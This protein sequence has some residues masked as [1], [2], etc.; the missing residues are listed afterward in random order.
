MCIT[1]LVIINNH[2]NKN[3]SMVI[4]YKNNIVKQHLTSETSV[5]PE[6][7][8]KYSAGNGGQKTVAFFLKMLCCRDHY[9]LCCM[10]IHTV[11]L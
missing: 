8:A 6:N 7:A 10:A 2:Y 11:S 5:Y 9:A 4:I 1:L 3:Y